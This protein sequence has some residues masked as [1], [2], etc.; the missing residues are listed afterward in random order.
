[1]TLPLPKNITDQKIASTFELI[2]YFVHIGFKFYLPDDDEDPHFD[3][4]DGDMAWLKCDGCPDGLKGPEEFQFKVLIL[5]TFGD[6]AS[7]AY[8]VT[9]HA[10]TGTLP[11]MPVAVAVPHLAFGFDPNPAATMTAIYDVLMRQ[12][13]ALHNWRQ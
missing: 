9:F 4:E 7:P 10:T 8:D 1:M 2:P 11:G 13:T 5:T 6:G 12:A 3:P